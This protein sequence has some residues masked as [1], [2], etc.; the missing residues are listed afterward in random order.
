LSSFKENTCPA[1]FLLGTGDTRLGTLRQFRDT[2]LAKSS[3]GKKLI[4]LYYNNSE[5]I[6][7]NLDYRPAIKDAA[8]KALELTIPIVEFLMAF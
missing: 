6:T 4:E 5:R 3:A 1:T 8:K 7:A 2:V